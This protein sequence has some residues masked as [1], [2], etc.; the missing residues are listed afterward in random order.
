MKKLILLSTSVMLL[1]LLCAC[2]LF[3]TDDTLRVGARAN[4]IAVGETAI[5]DGM[6]GIFSVYDFRLEMT[7]VDVVRGENAWDIVKSANE[8]NED[9]P[10][11]SG[12][13]YMLVK[14]KIKALK[15]KDDK[16]I[17]LDNFYPFE[18]VSKSGVT[19]RYAYV[20]D[21]RPELTSIYEGAEVEGYVCGMVGKG[22]EP[23]VVFLEDSSKCLWFQT[24]K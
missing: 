16:K 18:F 1:C 3:S 9:Y 4:P 21:V 13:E 19:Y 23:L 22:D 14:F 10:P 24:T 7:V 15:S 11:E 2:S 5:F 17:D 20:W 12:M 6:A 8:Y